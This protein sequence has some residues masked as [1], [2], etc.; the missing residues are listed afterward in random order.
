MID[1]KYWNGFQDPKFPELFHKLNR[2]KE[3]FAVG[4]YY[5]NTD[6]R[7]TES[8]PSGMS[9]ATKK[10]VEVQS[11][12]SSTL[13]ENMS[14]KASIEGQ[15]GSSEGQ[16]VKATLETAFSVTSIVSE[17]SSKLERTETTVE[18]GS[19]S[20]DRLY[21]QWLF[22]I[23]VALYRRKLDGSV[24]LVAVSEWPLEVI[25]RAYKDV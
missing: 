19:E 9:I 16:H 17:S 22:T 14:I 3:Y 8:I 23:A 6:A 5:V 24:Q 18:I 7:C 12:I 10:T 13:E 11:S 21:V 2:V 15:Y 25:E 4:V 1:K 20:F